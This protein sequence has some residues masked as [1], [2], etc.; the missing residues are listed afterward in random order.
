MN[1]SRD[2]ENKSINIST[3][4]KSLISY[5]F[6]TSVRLDDSDWSKSIWQDIHSNE[7]KL[8]ANGSSLNTK[9]KNEYERLRDRITSFLLE[10][11]KVKVKINTSTNFCSTRIKDGFEM[12]IACVQFPNECNSRW[13]VEINIKKNRLDFYT[14]LVC[15][16]I[17]HDGNADADANSEDESTQKNILKKTKRVRDLFF[18][19]YLD[20][21]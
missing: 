16:H 18:I 19:F 20:F 2:D 4:N 5:E 7:K 8:T 12:L 1:K 21:S 3:I 10:E 14:N 15:E 17:G 13:R 11:F 9:E 6:Q